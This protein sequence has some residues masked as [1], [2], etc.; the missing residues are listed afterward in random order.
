VKTLLKHTSRMWCFLQ[1]R[2]IQHPVCILSVQNNP[3][4]AGFCVVCPFYYPHMFLYLSIISISLFSCDI[5]QPLRVRRWRATVLHAT[6]LRNNNV[7]LPGEQQPHRQQEHIPVP[8]WCSLGWSPL[9]RGST[10][11]VGV[12]SLGSDAPLSLTKR[13]VD[14]Y[15]KSGGG[16]A[17]NCFVNSF[18]TNHVAGG[19]A[20]QA[21]DWPTQTRPAVVLHGTDVYDRPL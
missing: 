13:T 10:S 2:T 14:S 4:F 18:L 20:L 16:R 1:L 17:Q 6:C 3:C 5:V 21:R 15:S 9:G 19:G 7:I 8:G 11:L 12:P